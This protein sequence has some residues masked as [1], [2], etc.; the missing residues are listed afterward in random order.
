M[1]PAVLPFLALC[2][3]VNRLA[4]LLGNEPV[5]VGYEREKHASEHV[6]ITLWP[7]CGPDET[8]G[9]ELDGIKPL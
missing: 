6:R 1:N 2:K 4:F 8:H 3:K 5:P 7:L 9:K